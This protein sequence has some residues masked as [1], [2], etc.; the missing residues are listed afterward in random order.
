[1]RCPADVDPSYVGRGT[2]WDDAPNGKGMRFQT[3]LVPLAEGGRITIDDAG[4]TAEGCDAVTLLLV[5][6]TSY[7]GPWKSPSRAPGDRPSP[8]SIKT[9]TARAA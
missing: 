9:A 8:K 5:A 7:N 4:I 1:M 2:T 3:R 6:A